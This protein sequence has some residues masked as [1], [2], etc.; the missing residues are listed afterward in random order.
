MP[1]S[2]WVSGLIKQVVDSKVFRSGDLTELK[3]TNTPNS[4]TQEKLSFADLLH[5][6][7]MKHMLL[8]LELSGTAEET[9]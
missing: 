4:E 9:Y 5:M 6:S 8:L 1:V 7:A 3:H 2:R